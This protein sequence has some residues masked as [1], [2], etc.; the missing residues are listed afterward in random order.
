VVAKWEGELGQELSN[1][2]PADSLIEAGTA[3]EA[4]RKVA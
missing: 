2:V 3:A 4:V 1:D